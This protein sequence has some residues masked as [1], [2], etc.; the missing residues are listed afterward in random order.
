MDSLPTPS[1]DLAYPIENLWA[2]LNKNVKNRNP[3]NYE[4]LKQFCIE[5]W[6]QINPKNYLKNFLKR[7]KMVLK[8]NGNRLEDLK[9]IRKEKKRKKRM[10]KKEKKIS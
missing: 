5:E 10:R 6:N 7:V 4:Q 3:E 2:I 1:P 9:Q 8:I